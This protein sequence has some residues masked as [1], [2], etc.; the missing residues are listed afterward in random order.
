MKIESAHAYNQS[1]DHLLTTITVLAVGLYSKSK[2]GE[3][4]KFAC[5]LF[6][7]LTGFSSVFYLKLYNFDKEKKSS[8]LDL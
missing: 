4:Y 8:K 7:G 5:Y 6:I 3:T 2:P 1:I